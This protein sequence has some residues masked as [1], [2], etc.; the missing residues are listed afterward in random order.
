MFTCQQSGYY[1]F[2]NT[3]HLVIGNFDD[4]QGT[5]RRVGSR[6]N[7]KLRIRKNYFL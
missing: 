6:M 4:D 5:L 2:E 1:D 7:V 3:A